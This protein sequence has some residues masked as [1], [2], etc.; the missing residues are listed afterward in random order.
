[1]YGKRL[2]RWLGYTVFSAVC[3]ACLLLLGQYARPPAIAQEAGVK[4]T[5]HDTYVFAQTDFVSGSPAAL[6]VSVLGA[7]SL[8]ESVPIS[9]ADVTIEI[10]AD[11]EPGK[12]LFTGKTDAKGNANARFNIPDLPDGNYTMSIRTKSEFGQD[13]VKQQ[14]RLSKKF[15]ILLV[16][17]KPLYQPLQL[18][19]MRAL[20][21]N[22]FDLKP[23]ASQEL[24]LEVEDSKGNK[25]FKRKIQTSDYGIA[26]ADFQLADEINLG[27]YKVTALLGKYKSEKSVVVKKYV[28]PKFKVEVATDKKFYLPKE[29]VKGNLDVAYIFGKPVAGGDVEIKASTFDVEFKD[30]QT[31]KAKTDAQGRCS[32]EVTL[33]DYFVG[34]PLEKGNALLKL[35]ISVKDTADHFE[36]A[37]RTYSVSNNPMNVSLMPESGRLVPGVENTVYVVAAYPDGSPAQADVTVSVQG[38]KPEPVFKG[39]LKTNETGFASFSFTPSGDDLQPGQWVNRLGI[40]GSDNGYGPQQYQEMQMPVTVTAVDKQGWKA[41]TKAV[42]KAESGGDNV[43]LRADKAVY[44]CGETM[45]LDV[46]ASTKIGTAFIDVVKNRQTVL[47]TTVQIEN[48]RAHYD[49]DLTTDIFGSLEI[50]AYEVM[51]GGDIIRDSKV[52]YVQPAQDLKISVQ[53]DKGEYLPAEDCAI[54][55]VVTDKAGKPVPSALAVIIVDEAVYALQEMQPGLEKVYF[56]LAKELQEPKYGIKYA[57]VSMQELVSADRVETARQDAAKIL[58]AGAEASVEYKWV[59][60]PAE[61]RSQQ[62]MQKLGQVYGGF[63]NHLHSGKAFAQKDAAGNWNF[64]PGLLQK[65]IDEKTV[66]AEALKDPWGKQLTLDDLKKMSGSFTF[67]A[68][69]DYADAYRKTRMF[70]AIVDVMSTDDIVRFDSSTGKWAYVDGLTDKLIQRKQISEVDLKDT[71]GQAI[72]LDKLA[73]EH[74]AFTPDNVARLIDSQKKSLIWHQLQNRMWNQALTDLVEQDA[75]TKTLVYRKDALATLMKGTANYPRKLA[76]GNPVDLNALVKAEPAF[77]PD[78]FARMKMQQS[79]HQIGHAAWTLWRDDQTKVPADVIAAL[80]EKKAIDENFL[81][82][83]WGNRI[84]VVK[85]DKATGIFAYATLQKY[86][87]RS[88]GPDGMPNTGDDVDEKWLGEIKWFGG[89]QTVVWVSEWELAGE[90]ARAIMNHGLYYGDDMQKGGGRFG[91]R[92]VSSAPGAA[93]AQGAK[94]R[95]KE[96]MAS[97]SAEG[98]TAAA[99]RIR[100][101]FPETLLWMPSLITDDNGVA[102]MSVKMADSITTWRLTTSA[103][104]KNGLLGGTTSPIRCFQDFFVDIDLPVSLTQHDE[105]SIPVAV[106]NYLKE[107]QTVKLT[108]QKDEFSK[109]YELMDEPV[110]NVELASGDVKAVYFRIRVKDIGVNKLCVIAEGSKMS[111]AIRRTVEIVP[112]GKLFETVINDRLSANISHK[113][114]IPANSI[115]GSYKLLLKCYPGVFSQV[116]EGVEGMLGMPHG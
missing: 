113:I 11:K 12:V 29:T 38:K 42:L 26:A 102:T 93:R 89:D 70:R 90:K 9:G 72:T 95:A 47:S 19:H 80:L 53:P 94:G 22:E 5:L 92:A 57:P 100:E 115:D 67:D 79:V 76:D 111:D 14:V 91:G 84:E 75:A 52:A 1:M 18:V 66:A 77:S 68:W 37:T 30:F 2:R 28:L 51:P 44:N 96:E 106:Y 20:A 45:K 108:M 41:E 50:H 34:T 25:V 6:R 24:T 27:D 109:W 10:G 23:L 86:G 59:K 110:K 85:R 97:D 116:V 69:A 65:M 3:L 17:D 64:A 40:F 74:K 61:V 8:T 81:K 58:L 87:F 105:V 63:I 31:V 54:R 35:D 114:A 4:G 88:N 43:L 112:D 104:S 82:D 39:S 83:P 103:S 32:F 101:Y 13:A 49:L 73:S 36:K 48:G 56:T 33:P 60:N 78:N 99:I 62:H 21:L 46:L 107:S 15:K 71:R 98:E 16:T 55:F 7:R